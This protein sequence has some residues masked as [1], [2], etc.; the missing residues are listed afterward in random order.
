[1]TRDQMTRELT[2]REPLTPITRDPF[3]NDPGDPLGGLHVTWP[4]VQAF[5]GRYK[6][7]IAGVFLLT[8]V[9][10]YAALNLISEQYEAR[11]ALLV[12]VGRENLDAPASARNSVFSTGLRREELSSEVQILTSVDLLTKVVDEIGPEAFKPKRVVPESIF[13]KAKYYTKAAIRF[14]RDQYKE[15]LYA[16][17]LKKRLN[18]RD[19]AIALLTDDLIVEPAKDSDVIRMRLRMADPT[20]AT[21]IQDAVIQKYLSRRIQVRQQPGLREFLDQEASALGQTLTEAEQARNQLKTTS[22]LSVPTEQKA[23]LLRQI[24][25]VTAQRSLAQSEAETLARQIAMATRMAGETSETINTAKVETANQSRQILRERVTKL[26]AD[27]A[28]LLTKYQPSAETV[29]NLDTEIE[30]LRALLASQGPT[31]VG[32][33][34][35]QLNPLRQQLLERI[36]A[37]QVRLEGL[38]A[39]TAA[40]T[41]QIANYERELLRIERGDAQLTVIERGRQVAEEQYL[42]M[43]KRRQDAD[44]AAQLDLNR[45]SNV[46]V[47]TP[48]HATLEPVYPRKMLIMAM[49]LAVG[50]LLGVA[51]SLLR[52]WAHDDIR[53]AISLEAVTKLPVLG[54]VRFGD[55]RDR[56]VA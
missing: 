21:R 25:E 45:I 42:A 37:D 16:L 5:L 47:V 55:E 24:R 13:G 26:E 39:A 51:V 33:T 35:S 17:D 49:A 10:A 22:V 9:G 20:L 3:F 27:K 43:L 50:L 31:E 19:S 34:T 40:Q 6:W 7:I 15:V 38:R 36:Q 29:R 32:S 41:T 12:K 52:E 48:P 14:V 1:M 23:L 44:F 46:S 28:H 11:A 53:D 8:V 30:G 2:T 56:S 54:V 18:D 4:Q